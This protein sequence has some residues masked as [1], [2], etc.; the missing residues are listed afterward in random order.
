MNPTTTRSLAL[1][2]HFWAAPPTGNKNDYF[3]MYRPL[4][5]GA[6]YRPT[7]KSRSL[8]SHD[9]HSKLVFPLVLRYI[10]SISI[11][12]CQTHIAFKVSSSGYII[13]SHRDN[14]YSCKDHDP[15]LLGW[16]YMYIVRP[17]C[18]YLA[19]TG[20]DDHEGT[21]AGRRS[22]LCALGRLRR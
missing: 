17:A 8:T 5:T 7:V 11:L 4:L 6:G 22:S 10:D 14:R 19:D 21:V 1:A 13:H 12:V 2:L 16:W 3:E 9:T 15:F 18:L 20:R